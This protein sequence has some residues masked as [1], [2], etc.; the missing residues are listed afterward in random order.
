MKSVLTVAAVQTAPAFGEAACN[1][2]AALALVP[3]GCDLAVLPELCATGYQFASRDEALALAEPVPEGP[4][5]RRLLDFARRSGTTLVAGLAE[6]V[7]ASRRGGGDAG[8]EAGTG[9]GAGRIYNSAVL[10]RPDGSWGVYRKVHLFWD[11]KSLFD[12]GD[13][14]FPVFP[15]CGTTL[16]LMVCFDWIFPEAARTLALAGAAVVCHPSNLVLPHCPD[17]MITRCLENRVFAV[18]ANRVGEENRTGKPLR[19]IGRSQVVSPRGER[20]AACGDA[21]SGAAVAAIDLAVA[22]KRITP[23]NDLFADR[24]PRAYRL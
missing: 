7:P 4:S 22:D 6:S 19:F 11:E 23:R 2:E 21:G 16:G 10:C 5:C 8:G 14:G 17:A 20:L 9:G 1:V 15:G 13:L 3:P 12:A 18:T 24:R